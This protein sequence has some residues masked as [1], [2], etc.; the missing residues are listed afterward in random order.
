[1]SDEAAWREWRARMTERARCDETD[2]CGISRRA[3]HKARR[4]GC[5][6][7]KIPHELFTTTA[8]HVRRSI[9]VGA[10]EAYTKYTHSIPTMGSSQTNGPA[11]HLVSQSSH[12]ISP[13][14]LPSADSSQTGN[15]TAQPR[16]HHHH[17]H[18]DHAHVFPRI[19]PLSRSVEP[20]KAK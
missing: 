7:R 2:C 15:P 10:P 18:H 1:M 19:A 16:R 14:H 20:R 13:N 6:R 9:I 17:H 8:R 4:K 3:Y 5:D 11:P 12:L